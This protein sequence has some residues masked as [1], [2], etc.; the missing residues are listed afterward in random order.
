MKKLF[1]F[2]IAI[3][4]LYFSGCGDTIKGKSIAIPEVTK[5]RE[6]LSAQQFD[7]IYSHTSKEFQNSTSKEKISELFS[8]IN[9][10]LG[11][12]KSSKEINWNVKT[13]NLRTTVVLVYESKF[14]YGSAFET[15]T[16]VVSNGKPE[17]HG[18]NINSWE[19]LVK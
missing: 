12:L 8:A 18:Y 3:G 1:L 16:F 4:S 7:E 5:F 2:F 19:M 9:R 6:R 14:E 11:Q 10:K 17:L 13:Y 15:F